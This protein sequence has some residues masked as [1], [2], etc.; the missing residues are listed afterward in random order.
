MCVCMH[1]CPKGTTIVIFR[2]LTPNRYLLL[3]WQHDL[4][5]LQLVFENGAL[6]IDQSFEEVHHGEWGRRE[7]GWG[8]S[9]IVRALFLLNLEFS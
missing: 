7:R 9:R 5:Q 3:H 8:G 1:L 2:S 4:D 6:L